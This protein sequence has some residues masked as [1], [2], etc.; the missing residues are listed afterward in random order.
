MSTDTQVQL[1]Q[2]IDTQA[3][4]F[5]HKEKVNSRTIQSC[6]HQVLNM[7][8]SKLK[9]LMI[10]KH[11]EFIACNHHPHALKVSRHLREVLQQRGYAIFVLD[12]CLWI[13]PFVCPSVPL[14]DFER[15][16]SVLPNVKKELLQRIQAEQ[17]R[18]NKKSKKRLKAKFWNPLAWFFRV[19]HRQ[20]DWA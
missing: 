8:E 20:P 3:K 2:L 18:P 19:L 1:G 4:S 5:H 10:A 16:K 15:A 11:G 7:Q 12:S 17:L 14:P 9:Q 6:L 13:V